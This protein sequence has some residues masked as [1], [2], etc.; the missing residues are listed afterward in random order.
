MGSKRGF[1]L[2]PR[3]TSDGA[4]RAGAR[5]RIDWGRDSGVPLTAIQAAVHADEEIMSDS[6][7]VGD[8]A[9]NPLNQILNAP[10]TD[11]ASRSPAKSRAGAGNLV[12]IRGQSQ[13]MTE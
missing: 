1:E 7:G 11:R 8:Y 10:P 9:Q 3:L 2:D 13:V 12:T 5:R 4:L 6:S